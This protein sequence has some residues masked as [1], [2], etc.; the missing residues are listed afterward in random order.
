MWL[1]FYKCKNLDLADVTPLLVGWWG[2]I[3]HFVLF[4]KHN[5][6]GEVIICLA[7]PVT[8][9][10]YYISEFREDGDSMHE[11]KTCIHQSKKRI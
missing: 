3:V 2:K 7:W 4:T 11:N 1:Y 10:Q 6:E 9:Q 8:G 5:T